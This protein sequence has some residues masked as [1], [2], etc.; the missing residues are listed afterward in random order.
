ML[1]CAVN[2]HCAVA[3][4]LGLLLF[5][6]CAPCDGNIGDYQALAFNVTTYI[7]VV[8]DQALVFQELYMTRN[9]CNVT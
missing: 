1:S 2:V 7:S 6:C 9:E 4:L 8:F 5:L 3:A